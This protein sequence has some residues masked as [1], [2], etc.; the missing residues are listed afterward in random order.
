MMPDAK[1]SLQPTQACTLA[2]TL[3]Y[4]GGQGLHEVL[5]LTGAQTP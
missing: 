1:P 2:R 3:R 5:S 4:A